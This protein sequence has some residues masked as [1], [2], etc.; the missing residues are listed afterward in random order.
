MLS[1]S[2][3]P[4]IFFLS[5]TYDFMLRFSRIR[6]KIEVYDP[7]DNSSKKITSF[8]LPRYDL[9]VESMYN[10]QNN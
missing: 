5:F 4:I 10:R 7:V 9:V 2:K 6:P 3:V 8:Y 1:H